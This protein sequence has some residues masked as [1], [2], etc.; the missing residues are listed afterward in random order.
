MPDSVKTRIPLPRPGVPVRRDGARTS[1]TADRRIRGHVR[2]GGRHPRR[3]RS[4]T[5]LLRGA[6]TT[7]SRRRRTRSRRSSCTASRSRAVLGGPAAVYGGRGHS[8]G[9][10]SALVAAGALGF[11]DALRLVRL[12]G[13][14]MQRAGEEQ[15][16]D[17]GRG[18]GPRPPAVEESVPRSVR[19]GDR[20]V[21]RISTPPDRL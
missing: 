14:L 16:G 10:Y 11:E 9:E 12:R 5:D 21:A 18:G 19:R 2:A 15:P 7:S 1:A 4:S 17:D 6:R 3:S 13:E 8:L 20:A